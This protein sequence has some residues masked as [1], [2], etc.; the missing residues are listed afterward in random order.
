MKR[1]A[2]SAP[3]AGR[4]AAR[5]SHERKTKMDQVEFSNHDTGTPLSRTYPHFSFLTEEQCHEV[6]LSAMK[7]LERTGVRL[8]DPEARQLALDAGADA[9]DD[10]LVFLPPRLVEWALREA[11]P[12]LGIYNRDGDLAMEL[13]AGKVYYGTGSDCPNVIDPYTGEHRK[14]TL[15][16][17]ADLARLCDALPE[18]DFLMSMVLPEDAVTEIYDVL[19]FDAMI[20]NTTK[21][22]VVVPY[23]RRGMAVMW[24][25][26]SAVVG[27]SDVLRR[28][29]LMVLYSEPTS[30]LVLGQESVQKTMFAA[31]HHIPLLYATGAGLGM[32]VPVTPAGAVVLATAE[33]LAG[34]VVTQLVRPGHPFVF[35]AGLAPIDMKTAV[36]CYGGPEHLIN[37]GMLMSMAHYYDL[38]SWGFAGCSDSK[39]E[40][41]Q[42]A[43][44]HA[45]WIL[46][47]A[48]TGCN[49][50]HD[51]GYMESGLCFSAVQLTMANEFIRYARRVARRDAFDPERLALE[52]IHQVGPGGAFINN[53][54]THRYFRDNFFNELMDHDTYAGWEKGGGATMWERTR[55]KTQ[56]VLETHEPK[57]LGPEAAQA[58]DE[59]VAR[60][61][62][63]VK[64]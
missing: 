64:P 39:A 13:E 60:V 12:T 23:S 56:N 42:A 61:R 16:D 30:P 17:L 2:D 58:L 14:G 26:A 18:I 57:P 51:V 8:L 59:I 43:A 6:H 48:L 11:P 44:E 40:D 46:W 31:A 50:C 5:F 27:G 29:P 1:N 28:K 35:G 4:R 63:G 3:I 45:M 24:E 36:F 9:G 54:H 47:A 33:A 53:A 22:F 41:Q 7:V 25:M 19:Q 38:P 37:Q 32:T 20:R 15:K 21:P 52:T 34:N 10:S 62:A 49:L 55:K